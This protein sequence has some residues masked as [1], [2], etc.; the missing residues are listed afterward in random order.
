M[1][2]IHNNQENDIGLP[3]E[4]VWE[5]LLYLSGSPKHWT[6]KMKTSGE[7]TCSSDLKTVDSYNDKYIM[8][9]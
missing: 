2:E 6:W 3:G 7:K 1:P 8:Y 4:T 5:M 9:I